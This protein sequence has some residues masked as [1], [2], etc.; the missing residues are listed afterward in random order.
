MAVWHYGCM[1]LCQY[2]SMAAWHLGSMAVWHYGT[3]ALC[4]YGSM[5]LIVSLLWL[6]PYSLMLGTGSWSHIKQEHGPA[7]EAHPCWHMEMLPKGDGKRC[8]EVQATGAPP[9]KKPASSAQRQRKRRASSSTINEEA[10][11]KITALLIASD[12]LAPYEVRSQVVGQ[13]QVGGML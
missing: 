6:W 13:W 12:W 2:V 9:A 10:V 3:M 1:A 5:A 7:A 4:P 8:I 11:D